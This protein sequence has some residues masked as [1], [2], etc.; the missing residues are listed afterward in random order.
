[1]AKFYRVTKAFL[2]G[3]LRSIFGV[4]ETIDL[5]LET[6]I[7]P[8]LDILPFIGEP[9][10]KKNTDYT[11]PTGKL[12]II[13]FIN[14]EG[15]VGFSSW[16]NLTKTGKTTINLIYVG[17][18]TFHSDSHIYMT[19]TEGWTLD[20]TIGGAGVIA[21]YGYLVDAPIGVTPQ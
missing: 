11:V 6:A 5:Q 19:V 14:I 7:K 8:T 21:W 17:N 12:L 4:P 9:I 2:E 10:G 15:Q 1:M 16:L 3:I 20:V 13:T 18:Q